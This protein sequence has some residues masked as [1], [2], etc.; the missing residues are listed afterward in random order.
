MT[1]H[2]HTL[3]RLR[4][5]TTLIEDHGDELPLDDLTLRI[6]PYTGRIML[7][8]GQEAGTWDHRRAIV[9][10]LAHIC[11]TSTARSY[12]TSDVGLAIY[13]AESDQ[14]SIFTATDVNEAASVDTYDPTGRVA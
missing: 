11:D 8:I 13:E 12:F 6:S 10:K 2:T 5:L 4:L 14:W 7:Q 1:T 9:D 3:N